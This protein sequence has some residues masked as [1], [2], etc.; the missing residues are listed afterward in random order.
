MANLDSIQSDIA[1]VLDG[2][3]NTSNI[4]ATDYS[5]RTSFINKALREWQD[6]YDWQCLHKEYNVLVSTAT[7]NASIALPQDFRK[8]SVNPWVAGAEYTITRPQDARDYEDLDTR[9]E[10][11]GNPRTNYVL[12]V[13]GTTLA[14]GASVRV[15][16]Y[17]S[18]GSLATTTDIAPIPN[19]DFLVQRTIAYWYESHED[20]RWPGAKLEAER[21]L[22]S[23]IDYENVFPE[24]SAASRVRSAT[25][26][27]GFRMGED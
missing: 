16:Y 10:F 6:A 18:A 9:V 1:G 12:R 23:L 2:D 13:Y 5:L 19:V 21:I 11:I 20:D 14:S 22:A 17:S 4:N 7:G 15:P 24:G 26:R 25:E 3:S 8:P 27:A